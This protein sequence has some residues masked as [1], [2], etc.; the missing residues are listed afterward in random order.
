MEKW[1]YWFCLAVFGVRAVQW[2]HRARKG[3]ILALLVEKGEQ[4][5]MQLKDAGAP[6]SVYS[7]LAEL[8][9]EGLIEHRKDETPLA[10]VARGGLPRYLYRVK[11][12]SA[13]DTGLHSLPPG[14]SPVPS[15]VSS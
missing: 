13:G 7:Y 3:F 6:G 2:R 8:E 12:G 9:E 15:G 4:S 14:T 5:G 1:L 10:T 11:L